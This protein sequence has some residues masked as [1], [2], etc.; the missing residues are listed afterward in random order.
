MTDNINEEDNQLFINYSKNDDTL[1]KIK[2]VKIILH[3]KS[4]VNKDAGEAQNIDK[5]IEFKLDNLF[6]P[7]DTIND[8]DDDN[9][10]S[11]NNKFKMIHDEIYF[12]DIY[13]VTGDNV[14]TLF[15]KFITTKKKS[16]FFDG[17]DDDHEI[18]RNILKNQLFSKPT[19]PVEQFKDT[20][21]LYI[22]YLYSFCRQFFEITNLN[23]PLLNKDVYNYAYY[24]HSETPDMANLQSQNN[25]PSVIKDIT[26][27][28]IV[29]TYKKNFIKDDPEYEITDSDKTDIITYVNIFKLLQFILEKNK[30]LYFSGLDD[31]EDVSVRRP[32]YSKNLQ[33]N[34]K[35][36]ADITTS[37]TDIVIHFDIVMVSI[38]EDEYLQYFLNLTGDVIKTNIPYYANYTDKKYGKLNT[39]LV[40]S[41]YKISEM[42][43]RSDKL[44][45]IVKRANNDKRL[46]FLDSDL[47]SIL[48]KYL[49]TKHYKKSDKKVD[50]RNEMLKHNVK[51]ITD[52]F[53]KYDY[54]NAKTVSEFSKNNKM[55]SFYYNDGK[56]EKE[57]LIN[58]FDIIN[59]NYDSKNKDD[60]S[61]YN[62]IDVSFHDVTIDINDIKDNISKI[63]NIYYQPTV[64]DSEYLI[65]ITHISNEGNYV[66][67]KFIPP[68]EDEK[69]NIPFRDIFI[70]GSEKNFKLVTSVNYKKKKYDIDKQNVDGK[71]NTVKLIDKNEQKIAI[72]DPVA[73]ATE[74]GDTKRIY[75]VNISIELLDPTIEITD[76]RKNFNKCSDKCE[77]IDN[78]LARLFYPKDKDKKLTIFSRL[79]KNKK[80]IKKEEKMLTDKFGTLKTRNPKEKSQMPNK[81]GGK[82]SKKRKHNHK[83][84]T[85]MRFRS[86]KYTPKNSHKY[87]NTYGNKYGNKRTNTY[88]RLNPTKNTYK[89]TRKNHD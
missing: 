76:S 37:S 51:L 78:T 1:K 46:M 28:K 89:K 22:L 16:V 56:G 3:V 47:F 15:K 77:K 17:P 23:D 83:K 88:K 31:D 81:V 39:L 10:K 53:F 6:A 85:R 5:Q 67:I 13:N 30:I 87:G 7:N 73:D 70:R 66:N 79:F 2:E 71:T 61:K 86:R 74:S 29:N 80:S 41:E 25:N 69:E 82:Y 44:K 8:D 43:F 60:S 34:P 62:T 54:K 45:T 84:H 64:F 9:V 50:D 65:N 38:E 21:P 49:E 33:F 14:I 12:H 35:Y 75:K 11:M 52:L 20:Y 18:T 24:N 40:T 27:T 19:K 26:N 63:D 48:M 59:L 57:Y 55:A 42:D 4:N 36:M 58:S 68:I 32:Y 72:L